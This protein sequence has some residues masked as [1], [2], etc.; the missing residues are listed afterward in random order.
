MQVLL[1][2]SVVQQR[3]L[4]YDPQNPIYDPKTQYTTPKTPVYDPHNTI[5]D[6]QTP[7]YDRRRRLPPVAQVL[8]A[9]PVVQQCC[10]ICDPQN[11]VYDPENPVYDSQKPIYDPQDR[12][13]DPEN[14]IY[15]R[16]RRLPPVAQVL[17]A[18]PVVQQNRFSLITSAYIRT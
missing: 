3:H 1:V 17:L 8:L 7:I 13:Y 18:L 9:L 5:Y 6:P 4:I 2:L 15:D 14:Q 11:P 16:R 12:I 10:W